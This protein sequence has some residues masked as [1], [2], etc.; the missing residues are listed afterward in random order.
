M[1]VPSAFAERDPGWLDAFLDAHDFATLI[2]TTPDGPFASHVPVLVDRGE[3]RVVTGHLARA[4]PQARHAGPALLI[5]QGPH[6]YV[7]PSWYPDKATMARVPTWNYVAVHLAGAL[8]FF[9][10]EP[11]L[12]DLVDRLS[13]RHEARVGGDWHFDLA[14]EAERVQL[15]GIVGFRLLV[16][17][18]DAKAKLSQNHPDANRRAV[19]DR[20]LGAVEPRERSVGALMD[21]TLRVRD[22]ET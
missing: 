11:A 15:R 9:D 3:R 4:N 21:A 5:A 18:V 2:T 6:A 10:D 22:T 13:R 8:E 1:Y 14:D 12:A 16:D 17:R 7:S 19:A 20:L